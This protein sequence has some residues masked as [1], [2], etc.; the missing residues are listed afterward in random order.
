MCNLG[1]A[2]GG[3]CTTRLSTD[4]NHCGA[5]DRACAMGSACI[6]GA[7]E[8]AAARLV[9][10]NDM[11]CA[12]IGPAASGDIGPVKCWG[13][14]GARLIRGASGDA[15]RAPTQVDSIGRADVVDVAFGLYHL[16]HVSAVD[17]EV[18]CVGADGPWLGREAS[19]AG[20]L[21]GVHIARVPGV[22]KIAAGSAH[23][24]AL[25]G[26]G[27]VYC[28]GF[29]DTLG[30]VDRSDSSSPVRVLEGAS[31]LAAFDSLT[32]VVRSVGGTVACWGNAGYPEP[33]V[34][35]LSDG[36]PLS[37][38]KQL[39]AGHL[40]FG[41]SHAC[42]LTESG[43]VFCW[44]NSP[45]WAITPAAKAT[46]DRADPVELGGRVI[47]EITGTGPV[48]CARSDQGEV[49]CWGIND[50]G[51]VDPSA[52]GQTT[53]APRVVAGVEGLID[54]EAAGGAV[55]GRRR[56]GQVICWGAN[57]LGQLGDGTSKARDC[58][59]EVVGLPADPP[60]S[61]Q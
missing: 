23:T 6:E 40:A 44:G 54:I 20:E 48:T 25:T 24:C 5:C 10:G 3:E 4:P 18:R 59:R 52:P 16:C 45:Y 38:V 7:C 14:N 56:D 26:S 60:A 12:F 35:V 42:A 43:R 39:I 53:M 15:V 36:Q 29:G 30:G 50:G 28:W 17:D 2:T 27:A 57:S 51:A 58:P 11:M 37:D 8:Q 55:C 31:D 13:N 61:C 49:L 1:A 32:C 41:Y 21:P 34:L 19:G 22:T 46:F 47:V 33:T 9:G